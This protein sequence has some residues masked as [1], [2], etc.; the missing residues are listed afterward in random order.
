MRKHGY[1]TIIAVGA[2][3]FIF[4]VFLTGGTTGREGQTALNS[5]L[6]EIS[7]WAQTEKAQNYYPETL[8]EYINGAAEIYLAYDFR[9]LTVSQLK[10]DQTE[11]NIAVEI[12]D[13]GNDKNAFGIY[14]AERFTDNNFI[15]VGLQGYLEEGSLNFLVDRYYVKLL[16]FDC[17]DQSENVLRQFSKEIVKK[18]GDKGAF[19]P[20]VIKLPRE[21]MIPN[22]EKYILRN[23]L[24][25]SFLRNGYSANY[26]QGDLE[27]DCFFI[28]AKSPQDAQD[29]LTKYL[30]AKGS[31]SVSE[32]DL[33]Y[34]VKDRYYHN[35]YLAQSGNALCG[36]MKVKDGFEDTGEKYLKMLL[37]NLTVQ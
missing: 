31:D 25:Y 20:L 9:E 13:M 4:S 15:D 28:E 34:L 6:P 2:V 26:M 11:M 19:P 36:V 27:F 10:K 29:M 30:E 24:G 33:G 22:T 23:F 37:N 12:Y 14:S 3:A 21:G 16:C 7:G 1:F 18:A 32:T 35:I 5:L 8:F 17:D